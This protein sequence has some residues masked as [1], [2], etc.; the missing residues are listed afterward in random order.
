MFEK[1]ES[2][3]ARLTRPT[4]GV[5]GPRYRGAFGVEIRLYLYERK[6]MR[7]T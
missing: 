4:L 7:V 3:P 6:L 2:L 5:K 1:K